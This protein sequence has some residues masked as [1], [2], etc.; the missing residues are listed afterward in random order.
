MR[1]PATKYSATFERS[2]FAKMT[3][4]RPNTKDGKPQKKKTNPAVVSLR[5]GFEI[6]LWPH[7]GQNSDR[8]PSTD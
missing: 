8:S 7:T 5:R 3:L 4:H 1:N 2:S 6:S